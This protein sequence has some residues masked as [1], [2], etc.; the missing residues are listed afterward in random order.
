MPT[1]YGVLVFVARYFRATV[2]CCSR[3][4]AP[5]LSGQFPIS[6]R[7]DVCVSL[8]VGFLVQSC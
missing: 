5:G 2:E 3:E 8:I 7:I 4:T 6:C 1:N